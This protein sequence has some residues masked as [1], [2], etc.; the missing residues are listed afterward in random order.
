MTDDRKYLAESTR[1][2]FIIVGG[3]CVVAVLILLGAIVIDRSQ[4]ATKRT[5]V[6]A[7]AC[8]AHNANPRDV[9]LCI[10]LND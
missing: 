2:L 10:K 8:A 4:E 5:R 9:A 1:K 7:N 3:I 6:V